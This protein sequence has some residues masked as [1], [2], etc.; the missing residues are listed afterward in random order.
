LALTASELACAI[1]AEAFPLALAPWE[2]APP[3]ETTTWFTSSIRTALDKFIA[4]IEIR[5]SFMNELDR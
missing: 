3:G 4:A 1:P 5:Q 2:L